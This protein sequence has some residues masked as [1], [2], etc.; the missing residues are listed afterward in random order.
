MLL[1]FAVENYACFADQVV[2]S[3]RAVPG[4]A[5]PEGQVVEV[6]GIGPVLR[7]LVLYGPNASG[8][9]RLVEAFGVLF[10]LARNGVPPGGTIPVIPHKLDPGWVDKPSTFEVE[11]FVEGVH[12]A[13]GLEATTEEVFSEWLY[14]VEG[15]RS[16]AIFER[17]KSEGPRPN[18][19]IGEG[20]PLD[21]HRRAF[22]GF[23][24]EGTR[25]EQPFLAELRA[26]NATE[27]AQ[28]FPRVGVRIC[29]SG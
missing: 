20:L 26:R 5:H 10:R 22:Y 1:Q 12:Y 9:S 16:V 4:E 24:A 23:V 13:Y 21:E 15:K 8:K 2:L 28:L 29:A 11:L 3:L 18:I 25:P 17:E 7:T 19:I 27:L 14:R 6:P